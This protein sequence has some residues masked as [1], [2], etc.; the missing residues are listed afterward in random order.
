MNL[1]AFW[2]SLR[3]PG[4]L[5]GEEWYN[6]LVPE[7]AADNDCMI[8]MICGGYGDDLVEEEYAALVLLSSTLS[9]ALVI[10]PTLLGINVKKKEKHSI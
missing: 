7:S 5:H 2:A 8:G 1:F 9:S 3:N 10:L 4:G 6:N